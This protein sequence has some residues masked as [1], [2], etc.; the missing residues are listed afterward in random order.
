M[1]LLS[2]LRTAESAGWQR[3][4]LII[5]GAVAIRIALSLLLHHTWDSQ[6]WWNSFIHLGGGDPVEALREPYRQMRSLTLFAESQKRGLFYEYW[7]YPPGMLYVYYPLARLYA[8]LA[9]GAT[10]TFSGPY[11]FVAFAVPPVFA[12]IQNVPNLV[13]DLLIGWML[14][15]MAGERASIWYL[16]NPYVLLMSTWMFDPVMVMFIVAAVYL[17]ERDR[18]VPAA[19]CLAAGTLVKFMPGVLVPAFVIYLVQREGAR[20]RDA[21]RFVVAYGV[22]VLVFCLP[23]IGDMDV[24]VRFQR[25]RY[26]G[27]LTWHTIF[28]ALAVNFEKIDWRPVFLGISPELGTL[29]LPLGLLWVSV[30][31]L[32]KRLSLVQLCLA[33]TCTYLATTKLVN[34]VYL[35]PVAALATIEV[36]R[37]P[38][39]E[40]H[41]LRWL[42]WL[43]PLLWAIVNVPIQAFLSSLAIQTGVTADQIKQLYDLRRLDFPLLTTILAV[44]GTLC[45]AMYVWG[46]RI[47]TKEAQRPVAPH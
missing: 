11:A 39:T 20:V 19:M 1:R 6:T 9:P 5:G 33:L 29:L 16:F 8:W 37:R 21:V 12:L 17:Q 15:R 3:P 42:F 2:R 24:V 10:P 47:F 44:T 27:G 23:V 34:E 32:H 36:A 28:H 38:S 22:T 30:Y 43:I 13:A 45:T 14:W 41:L 18:T 40:K 35:L 7:A 26:G 4:A 31:L 46:I 25:E